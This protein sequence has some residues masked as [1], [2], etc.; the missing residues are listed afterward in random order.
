MALKGIP[1]GTHADLNR[2]QPGLLQQMVT[3]VGAA[4]INSL[5]PQ[6]NPEDSILEVQAETPSPKPSKWPKWLGLDS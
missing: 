2:Y 1:A 4:V 6:G 3:Q 5:D